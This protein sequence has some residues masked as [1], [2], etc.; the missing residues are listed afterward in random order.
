MKES[1]F[2]FEYSWEDLQPVRPL[3]VTALIAQ[4]VGAALGLWIAVFPSGFE[5]LWA[6]GALA[7]FP[8]Y[9]L[10]LPLQTYLRPGSLGENRIMVLRMGLVALVL[11]AAV[12]VFPFGEGHAR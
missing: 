7:T 9:L 1:P 8:G 3:F 11:S 12:F 5:N 10:G 6:G 2:G 4:L